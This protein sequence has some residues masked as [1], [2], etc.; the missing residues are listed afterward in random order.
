M[1]ALAVA[2]ASA[3]GS[4]RTWAADAVPGSAGTDTSLPL[5]DS[6]LTV[7]GRGGF[8]EL[9][10]TVNQTKNL[11]NQAVSVTWTGGVPTKKG[12]KIFGEHFLQMFQCWGDDDGSNPENPGPPPEQCQQ[13]AT[14]GVDQGRP[15]N[16]SLFEP[17]ALT[18]YI[19]QRGSPSFDPAQGS[20]DARS[21]FVAKP[22]RAVD[23]TVVAQPVDSSFNANLGGGNY[24]LNPYFNVITTNEIPGARTAPDG[25]GAEL[26]EATT[27]LE[28]TGL[29]C[30]QSVQKQADGSTKVPRCWIVVVPRGSAADEN[31]GTAAEFDASVATSPLAPSAWKNRIAFPLEFNP[32]DSSCPLA[33]EQRRI[34]GSELFSAAVASWQPALCATPGLSP[35]A[36]GSIS[37]SRARQQL[38]S[39]GPGAPGMAVVSR[40][41][42]PSTVDAK[43]PVMYS[44]LALSGTVIGFNVERIPKEPVTPEGGVTAEGELAGVRVAQ[45]NLTPRLVAK[46][47]TQSYRSQVEI[48]QSKPPY[49]WSTKNPRHLFQDPDFL[50]FNPEFDLLRIGFER[51]VGGLVVGGPNSDA[52]QQVWEWVFS[53]PEARAWLAGTP[54][55]WEM[56]VNPIYSTSPSVNP[57]G[58]SFGDPLPDSYPK[59]DPYCYQAPK[60]GEVTPPPLCGLDWLPYTQGMRDSART[61]RAVND[62]AK[63]V[64]DPS[65]ISSDRVYKIDGPQTLGS[66]SILSITDTASAAQYGV[67]MARLSRA[68][69]NGADRTF[70]AADGAGL[71]AGVQAM[72]AKA[73]PGFLEPNPATAPPGAYPLTALTYAVV[74]PLVLDATARNEYAA[75]VDYAAGPGQIPGFQYGQ[76]PPGYEPLPDGLRAV[77]K[78]AA[79][80]IRELTAPAETQEAGGP[81]ENQSAGS[82]QQVP[83]TPDGP[84][85]EDRPA[86]PSPTGSAGPG[87]GIALPGAPI[88]AE[89]P[90]ANV[91]EAIAERLLTPI[92]KLAATRY[93]LPILV[94][95][96]VLSGLGALEL[97]KRRPRRRVAPGGVPSA[98]PY[99]PGSLR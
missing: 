74:T 38:L 73:V 24:W 83:S 78:R 49:E 36:Y 25:T 85:A 99:E 91:V 42:D 33:A 77:G 96:A 66:R 93:A 4:E 92:Y 31:E 48:G 57:Q 62:G 16:V 41:L 89:K 54:D 1:A 8:S 67:Q 53:D 20:L 59:S 76:L 9:K 29:G 82:P 94:V 17:L 21:G 40:P 52:A 90:P 65:A 80:T 13:G 61:T 37:D 75:F 18:R 30:G 35:Y 47:L 34:V 10:V 97:T 79:A 71:A 12:R 88:R 95:V 68:G 98:A 63:I 44:P 3:T 46:L 72:V 51:N 7:S 60:V 26:L 19:S 32:V 11:S 86:D 55:A 28:S 27:G 84:R 15:A 39:G 14:D 69:D 50:Q 45:L 58:T 22:F 56:R 81:S 43:N 5:T 70:I 64:A 6:K 2:T 23:G 87:A